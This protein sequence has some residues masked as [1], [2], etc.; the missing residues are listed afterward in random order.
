MIYN[1]ERHKQLVI[2]LKDLSREERLEL[3]HYNV[4]VEEQVFWTHREKF[5]R[6]MKDFLDNVLDFD[7]FETA[8]SFLYKEVTK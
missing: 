7:Q 5:V 2:R 6:I 8:F 3:N 1:K 4:E